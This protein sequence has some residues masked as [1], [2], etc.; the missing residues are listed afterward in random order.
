MVVLATCIASACLVQLAKGVVLD[1][2]ESATLTD[3]N[4]DGSPDVL[5]MGFM[6]P[7]QYPGYGTLLVQNFPE[8]PPYERRSVEAFSLAGITAVQSARLSFNFYDGS[9]TIILFETFLSGGDGQ[10]LL[11]DFSIPMTN[12]GSRNV[13]AKQTFFIS[14]DVTAELNSIL[15]GGASFAEVRQQIVA[16]TSG[17]DQVLSPKLIIT[18]A[19]EPNSIV[20]GVV[21]ISILCACARVRMQRSSVEATTLP[22]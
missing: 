15:S 3:E 16:G 7:V 10:V 8:Q 17:G 12:L 4:G 19:P 20:L 22:A 5:G 18:P 2:V 11:S 14:Y 13:F 9:D 21:G 6:H 1:P